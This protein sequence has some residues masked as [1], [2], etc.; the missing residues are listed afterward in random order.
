MKR[1]NF[2]LF[3]TVYAVALGLMVG[4]FNAPQQETN[5]S[6]VIRLSSKQRAASEASLVTD[7]YGNVHIFWVENN[8][9]GTD[10]I[11]YTRYD[12]ETWSSPV[13]IYLSGVNSPIGALAPYVD[14]HG[15]LHLL[16]TEGISP[17]F[18]RYTYA[19]A[20]DALSGSKWAEPIQIRIAAD[21]LDFLVDDAGVFH[22][23]FS[24]NTPQ[25][26]GL[27]Y[28]Q[29]TDKGGTWSTPLW[30]DPDI[31]ENLLPA[32]I[33][34]AFD[35]QGGM[36]AVWFYKSTVLG[37]DGD[38]VRYIR[39][40]DGGKTWSTPFTLAKNSE[41]DDALNNFA[42]P[43]MAVNGQTIH[44]VWAGGDLLYRR[45]RYSSDA[46]TTWSDTAQIMG[47]L[48][49]QA[50]DGMAIDSLGRPHYFS[51]IR[52]PMGI[53]HSYLSNN[54]WTYPQ[55]IYFIRFAG[56]KNQDSDAVEAHA[57]FPAIRLGNQ[58]ILTFTDNPSFVNRGLYVM[59]T[60]LADAP[61]VPAAPPVVPGLTATPAAQTTPE[62]FASPTDIPSPTVTATP[63]FDTTPSPVGSTNLA[64]VWGML[65]SFI[66]VV[67]VL[68][69]RQFTRS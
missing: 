27:F 48:N 14:T 8:S 13:D 42:L 49:G 29:S 58:V 39:S 4:F 54:R 3:F 57:T 53:Y 30:L 11:L 50:G 51:Q 16:W 7:P 55:L 10:L 68:V 40:L 34:L 24:M 32:K 31:P 62:N 59:M 26:R 61:A 41:G 22:A 38:W 66:L 36:H 17:T 5:W 52:F 65:V 35:D 19:P 43:V 46:G 45:Y 21:Q 2:L 47:N 23:L 63:I 37:L 9:N 44:V 69:F 15:T 1:R 25:N 12:G 60:T 64:L 67:G 56:D 28:S 33:T 6:S 20:V 18:M